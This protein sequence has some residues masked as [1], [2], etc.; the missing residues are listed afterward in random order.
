MSSSAHGSSAGPLSSA[1]ATVGVLEAISGGMYGRRGYALLGTLPNSL[2]YMEV[3]IA[4][5][6]WRCLPRYIPS[7]MAP[8]LQHPRSGQDLALLGHGLGQD[9]LRRLAPPSLLV[10][11]VSRRG[12]LPHPVVNRVLVEL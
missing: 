1:W 5:G 6:A 8:T 2:I 9:D 12:R 4:A 7:I 10:G 11:E 3:T